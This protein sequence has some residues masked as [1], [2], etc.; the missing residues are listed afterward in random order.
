MNLPTGQTRRRIFTID[1]SN[2]ADSRKMYPLWV[3]LILLSILR[4]KYPIAPIFGAWIAFLSQTGKILKVSCYQNYCIDFNQT[5]HNDTDHQE[6]IVGGTNMRPTKPRWRTAAILKKPLNRISLWLFDRFWWNLALWRI[7]APD[8]GS[9][10][11]A[12]A[13][14]KK[15]T[16]IEISPQWFDWSL[17]NLVRWCK[18]CLLISW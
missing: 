5:W 15:I 1:T 7:L 17:R 6:V 9:K 14:L 4:V 3:S 8:S 13:I 2:D 11:A 18:M 10:M 16:K 12:A